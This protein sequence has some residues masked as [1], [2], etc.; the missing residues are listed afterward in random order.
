MENRP[1]NQNSAA[2]L[3]VTIMIYDLL[4]CYIIKF[5]VKSE[6]IPNNSL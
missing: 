6:T 2:I 1:E 4:I 5:T 3:V